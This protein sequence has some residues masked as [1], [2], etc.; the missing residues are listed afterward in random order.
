M[1]DAHAYGRLRP[2]TYR[3]HARLRAAQQTHNYVFIHIPK[4]GGT[5]IRDALDMW[6]TSKH[7]TAREWREMYPESSGQFSFAFVRNPWDRLISYVHSLRVR[8]PWD[9]IDLR[10]QVDF[11]LNEDRNPMVDFVGRYET[12]AE[13]FATICDTIGIETPPLP[14]INRSEHN[15]YRE[16]YDEATKQAIAEKY[17]DD[18]ALFGYSF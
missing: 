7:L 16:Y 5:S 14:H 3:R 2:S 8:V 9:Q 1:V 13:D 12:L 15:H 10:P 4:T 11:I 18:I 6:P 17:A